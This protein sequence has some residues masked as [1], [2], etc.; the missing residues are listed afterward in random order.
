MIDR[1]EEPYFPLNR[2]YFISVFLKGCEV[3]E[4]HSQAEL[5]SNL[6]CLST[7]LK[8]TIVLVLY[9]YWENTNVWLSCTI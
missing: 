3:G 5:P 1:V 6:S 8:H 9:S 4:L 2:L 7:F